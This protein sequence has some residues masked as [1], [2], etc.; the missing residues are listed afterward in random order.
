MDARALLRR[1]EAG[2]AREL[3]PAQLDSARNA[4]AHAE[5]LNRDDGFAATRD[6]AYIAARRAQIAEAQAALV[7]AE[8]DKAN[9]D[10]E[11]LA[12]ATR[13]AEAAKLAAQSAET[14][15]RTEQ[16]LAAERRE[17]EQL[18]EALKRIATVRE[19][20]HGTVVTLP[21]AV[22]FSVGKA[23][24][25]P[26][27]QQKL[28]QLVVALKQLSPNESFVV[29]GYTDSTGSTTLNNTLSQQRAQAVRDYLISHGIDGNRIQ[30]V[31]MGEQNP[32]EDNSSPEGRAANRRVEIV[33]NRPV[34]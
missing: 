31:G 12:V 16:E 29:E 19:E 3:A 5:R 20:R 17:R 10:K 25:R 4:L 15:R 13:A 22:V 2:P 26:M 21:G 18:S 8:R 28:N 1:A 9:A 30:A 33:I 34:G 11:R 32:V 23:E 7:G 6:F 27:A 14:E 24:L